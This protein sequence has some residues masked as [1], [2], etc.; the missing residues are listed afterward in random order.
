MQREIITIPVGLLKTTTFDWDIEWRTQGIPDGLDGHGG[1]G[2]SDFPRW[3][4]SPSI[5]LVREAIAQWRA[6]RWQAQGRTHLY[7]VTIFDPFVKTPARDAKGNPFSTGRFFSTDQGFDNQPFYTCAADAAKGDDGFTVT[8]PEGLPAPFAGQIVSDE[9]DWP[10][11]ITSVTASGADTY[12]LTV[13]PLLRAAI[14]SGSA[15]Y[16]RAKG[17]FTAPEDQMGNPSFDANWVSRPQLQFREY[18]GR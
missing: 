12:D 5:V 1:V 18:L 3:I 6:V 14:P 4:G 17:L 9:N 8:V 13:R 7:R 15:I 2:I 11:G 10:V 16:L